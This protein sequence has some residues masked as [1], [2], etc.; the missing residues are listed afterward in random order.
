MAFKL[1]PGKAANW[2]DGVSP[3]CPQAPEQNYWNARH[4]I[5]DARARLSRWDSTKPTEML[6][7]RITFSEIG[8]VTL[9]NNHILEITMGPTEK[10]RIHEPL[11]RIRRSRY[12]VDRVVDHMLLYTVDEVADP[13]TD[14]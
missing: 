3:L 10:M 6:V 4:S 11:K 14:E 9:C 2:R 13:V 7:L 5:T 1:N 8:L 12:M